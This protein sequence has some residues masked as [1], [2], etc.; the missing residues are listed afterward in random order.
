MPFGVDLDALTPDE[1]PLNFEWDPGTGGKNVVINNNGTWNP[2]AGGVTG[3]GNL[4]LFGNF[5]YSG[6]GPTPGSSQRFVLSGLNAGQ[7][8]EMR[9]FVRKWDNGTVRPSALKMTNGTAVTDYLILE[10]RPGTVTGN[11]NDDTAYYISYTYVAQ[12]PDLIMDATVP[13]VSSANG[14][15]HLYG[16]TNRQAA[17][18]V[19]AP[20]MQNI[21]RANNGASVTLTIAT[22]PG[23]TYAVDYSTTLTAAGQPGGWVQINGAVASQGT[24]TTYIDTQ[25][26]TLPGAFYRVR[27]ITK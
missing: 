17:P 12:G 9:V 14:S 22:Q 18:S 23:R 27:D 26:S 13:A 19:P 7:S 15:F 2:T 20:V 6:G 10:D 8:Y 4:S 21:V 3:D 5:T 25:F 24:Q 16:L 11:G 1:T